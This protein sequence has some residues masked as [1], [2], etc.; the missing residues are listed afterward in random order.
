M[1]DIANPPSKRVGVC[2]VVEQFN[3]VESALGMQ[4][5]AEQT[6]R[7]SYEQARRHG[8]VPGTVD[9]MRV[10]ARMSGRLNGAGVV[11]QCAATTCMHN[12]KSAASEQ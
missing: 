4:L 9:S 11:R 10:A 1:G 3:E 2:V 5:E 6:E 8:D 12:T 7:E